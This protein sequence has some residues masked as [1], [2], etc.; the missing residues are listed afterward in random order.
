MCLLIESIRIEEG[1]PQLLDYHNRRMNH[2]RATLF[3]EKDEIDLHDY[4]PIDLPNDQLLKWRI[5]YEK[6]VVL[7]EIALYK[8]REIYKLKLIHAGDITYRHKYLERNELDR[9][10]AQRGDADEVILINLQGQITD[11]YYFS[12][13]F[14]KNAQYHAPNSY[15]LPSVMRSYLLNEERIKEHDINVNDILDYEK[16]HLVNALNPLGSLYLNVNN[17]TII[18]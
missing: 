6:D 13:V 3:G 11:A 15:L 5:V 1:R 10:Y 17:E 9:L 8:P 2:S 12:L 4:I 7:S 16:I 14:E 18:Y